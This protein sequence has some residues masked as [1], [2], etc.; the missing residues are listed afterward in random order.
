MEQPQKRQYLLLV[1]IMAAVLAGGFYIWQQQSQSAAVAV[2][3]SAPTVTTGS[4]TAG[5]DIVVYV[6]G[7]VVRPG[8]Y[9]LSGE[10][11]VVDFINAA[12][13]F[14]AGAN[15]SAVNLA[16]KLTDGMQVHVPGNLSPT[17]S[18][19]QTTGKVNLNN[20]DKKQMES[21][22]G[23]GPALADRILEYRATQGGFKTVDEL[24]KVSGIGDV[25]Y[26]SIKD[27]VSL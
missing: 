4:A 14:A 2:A 21:L 26:N 12:G 24:K 27:K 10:L 19:G 11:R 13:G 23:I 17:T 6:S 7:F 15:A 22:P 1:I 16:Q 8:V 3:P 25:K 5:A 9:K 20:A 18:G